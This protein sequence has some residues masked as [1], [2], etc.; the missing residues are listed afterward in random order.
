MVCIVM[1]LENSISNKKNLRKS[2]ESLYTGRKLV[3]FFISCLLKDSF[4]V[5]ILFLD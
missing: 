3:R 1:I 5:E 4:C 2:I